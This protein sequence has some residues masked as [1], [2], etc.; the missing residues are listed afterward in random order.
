MDIFGFDPLTPVGNLIKFPSELDLACPAME[1]I[2]V[3]IV[4]IRFLKHIAQRPYISTRENTKE[5]DPR[6]DAELLIMR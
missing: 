3:V 4:Q 5:G 2:L 1:A 6:N